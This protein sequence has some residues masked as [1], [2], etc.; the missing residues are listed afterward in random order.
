[1]HFSLVAIKVLSTSAEV[2]GGGARGDSKG[3]EPLFSSLLQSATRRQK[4][5]R[6]GPTAADKS[7]KASEGWEEEV[8]SRD[9]GEE[10]SAEA[11][12]KATPDPRAHWEWPTKCRL[13]QP[14]FLAPD[15][16]IICTPM[17]FHSESPD[18]DVWV[19][20]QPVPLPLLLSGTNTSF[21]YFFSMRLEE[22]R[23]E[24]RGRSTSVTHCHVGCGF[25]A[26]PGP[27]RVSGGGERD[28]IAHGS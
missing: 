9:V 21:I 6:L 17:L 28:N 1:M 18:I 2:S 26:T 10:G 13:S 12:T 20:T 8:V 27:T 4:R 23:W 25:G 22:E 16:E 7:S 5:L 11:L 14:F 24:R 3:G 15:G 19:A